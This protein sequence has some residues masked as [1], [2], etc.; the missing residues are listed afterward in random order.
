[1]VA[2][3][4]LIGMGCASGSSDGPSSSAGTVGSKQAT[5]REKGVKFAEC[6]RENGVSDFPDP[7]AKG[8]FVYGATVSPAVFRKAVDAC[9]DLQPPGTLSVTR[10]P[11]QQSAG[12][13]FAQ[14]MRDNGVEDFPDPVNGEPLINTTRIPSSNQPGGMTILDAAMAQCRD[15]LSKA[16]DGQ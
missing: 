1:M 2:L 10:N 4:S 13:E 12:L 6:V 7:D 3:I 11:E 14:C 8:E 5:D 16:A 9:K 15:L